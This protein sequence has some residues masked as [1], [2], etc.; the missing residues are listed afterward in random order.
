MKR[1]IKV[2]AFGV[3]GLIVVA[4]IYLWMTFGSLIKGAMSVE[5][6][7]DGLYYMEYK[8]DDGFDE[9]M[10]RGGYTDI[11]KVSEYIMAFLSKGFFET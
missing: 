2:T 1:I 8:G 6:L 11:G 7:D 9:L 10:A 4:T 3:L 5:K